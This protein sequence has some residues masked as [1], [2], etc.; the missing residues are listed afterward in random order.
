MISFKVAFSSRLSPHVSTNSWTL[1]GQFQIKRKRHSCLEIV[2]R[3][4]VTKCSFVVLIFEFV[5]TVNSGVQVENL[6]L[7]FK[8]KIHP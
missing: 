7:N 6:T 2:K 8:L 4:S 5:F 3:I 1:V